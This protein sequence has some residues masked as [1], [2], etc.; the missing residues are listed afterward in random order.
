MDV[1]FLQLPS[2]I[3]HNEMKLIISSLRHCC[4]LLNLNLFI[5]FNLVCHHHLV[6]LTLLLV[7]VPPGQQAGH[8]VHQYPASLLHSP[9]WELPGVT[10]KSYT[11]SAHVITSMKSDTDIKTTQI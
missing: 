5:F 8:H 1:S 9:P 7:P 4:L 2:H 11:A 6:L 10:S 3:I